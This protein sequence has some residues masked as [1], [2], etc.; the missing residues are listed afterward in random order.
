[1]NFE[2]F[3]DEELCEKAKEGDVEAE[4]YLINK[5]KNLVSIISLFSIRDFIT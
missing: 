1:M 3:T 5:Y 4:S 2:K